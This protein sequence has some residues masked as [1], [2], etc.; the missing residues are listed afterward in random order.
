MDDFGSMARD[1]KHRRNFEKLLY[2]AAKRGDA[3]LVTERLS[4]G[5]DPNCTFAKDRTPLIANVGGI[6]PSAPTVQA[7]LDRGADASLMDAAGLTAL[8]YARRKLAR[9]QAKPARPRRKSP[10][11]DENDQLRLS[12]DERDELDRMRRDLAGTDPGYLRIWWQ[13]R[14]RAARRVFNDPEQVEKIVAILE[15]AGGRG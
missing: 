12:A 9:L 2:L 11:L 5:I 3:A 6:S 7:L 13:E 14:L 1:P 4:W 15:A 10:S 8:D